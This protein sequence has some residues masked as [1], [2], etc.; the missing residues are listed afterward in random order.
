MRYL[1]E[2]KLIQLRR[3]WSK[4]SHM[5]I[6]ATGFLLIILTG[7]FLLMLPV[8]SRDR[9]VTGFLECL[10]TATSATCVTGLV[11]VDTWLHWSLFG[12]LVILTMIQ[13]GGLG[14]MTFGVLFSSILH[15]KISMRQ[16]G[17]L[18]DS[19]NAMQTGGIVHMMQK[20]CKGTF[21]IE[22][23]GAILL[24]IRFCGELGLSRGIYYGIFHSISAFCNAGFD[25][26]G[27]Q[28]PYSSMVNY[29]ADWL[30]NLTLVALILTGGIGFLVWDDITVKKWN[31]AKYRLHT[32]IVLSMTLILVAG[33]TLLFYL[34][35]RNN[36]AAGMGPG[37]TFLT[38]LFDAVTPRTAGF[39]TTDIAGLSD[40]GKLL[41][42]ILM[43]IGGNSGSTAGGIKTTT[44]LVFFLYMWS[45]ITKSRG[46]TIFRRRL[47]DDAIKRASS[48][49][50]ANLI[51]AL[52]AT[53]VICGMQSLD[54]RDVALETVSAI[55]TVGM[56]TGI[57]RALNPVSRL[58][59]IL[60]MYCGRVGSLS[61]LVSFTERKKAAVIEYPEEKILIG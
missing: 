38:C 22:G 47:E 44:F 42:L 3:N 9:T 45:G 39:N 15:R 41:S 57:T 24:S 34:F 29:S 36:L 21:L 25:L 1:L 30:V 6:L 23:I 55:S 50:C 13:I 10:F 17:I 20:I 49:A 5:Q 59:I 28:G 46:I 18:S 14:F 26:M 58:V 40:A 37:E 53:L 43:F 7:S 35:E 27:Y 56:S 16:K 2:Q 33:G 61:I 12:Q 31:F 48:V 51:L 52:T 4:L 11:V 32:K 60:L 8:S 54:L 19:L